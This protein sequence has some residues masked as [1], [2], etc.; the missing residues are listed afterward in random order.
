MLKTPSYTPIT[1]GLAPIMIGAL[2]GAFLPFKFAIYLLPIV[3]T[4]YS[5]A[6]YDS[7]S[8]L[9]QYFMTWAMVVPLYGIL[10]GIFGAAWW[11]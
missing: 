6:V 1:L 4:I 3:S 11:I 10:I 7:S 2:M 9:T 5:N 8:N